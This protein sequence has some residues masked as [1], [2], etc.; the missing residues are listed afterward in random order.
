V[1]GSRFIVSIGL[2]LS[3]ACGEAVKTP[4]RDVFTEEFAFTSTTNERWLF[5]VDDRM[6]AMANE[7][8]TQFLQEFVATE[9]DSSRYC[10][11]PDPAAWFPMRRDA[12][13]VFPSAPT[14]ERLVGPSSVQTLALRTNRATDEVMGDW[15]RAVA[16]T[17]EATPTTPEGAFALLS[18]MAST[19]EL[20][21]EERAPETPQEELVAESASASDPVLLVLVAARDDESEGAP[22]DYRLPLGEPLEGPLPLGNR[23]A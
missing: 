14:S 7:L 22:R 21:R 20:L 1:R 6:D 8:R 18:A 19:V 17:I 9:E 13:V 4:A 3:L 15:A 5:V 10:A 12:F 11:P 2:A 23:L 16:D